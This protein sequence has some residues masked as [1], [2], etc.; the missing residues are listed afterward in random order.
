M[1]KILL[2]FMLVVSA[3]SYA[4][5]KASPNGIVSDD[6]KGYF[7]FEIEGV[8]AKE[9]YNRLE[10]FIVS[11]YRN[12]DA[13]ASKKP[14]EMINVHSYSEKAFPIKTIFG[15]KH[16]A[17]VD[18][19]IVFRFKDGKI[20]VDAPSINDMPCHTLENSD[21]VVFC[22]TRFL[23]DNTV[24]LYD[25]KGKVKNKKVIESLNSWIN[26]HISYIIESIQESKEVEDSW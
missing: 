19:N 16:Y 15:M 3:T 10:K 6:G 9:I 24:F 8:S 13:V 2:L 23:T 20:R 4:Q 7:V 5:F 12:P 21:G 11:S 25:K 17:N 22:G 18:M 14:Y 26:L 1:K